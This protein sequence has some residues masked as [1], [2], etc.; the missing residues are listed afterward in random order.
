MNASLVRWLLWGAASAIGGALWTVKSVS[1]LLVNRQ[2][3]FTFEF[4]PFFFGIAVLGVVRTTA[5]FRPV[6]VW[7]RSLAWL[8]VVAGAVA[9]VTYLV[10]RDGVLFGSAIATAMLAV[11]DG[12]SGSGALSRSPWRGS[13]SPRSPSAELWLKSMNGC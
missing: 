6:A 9:A 10:Q 12:S 2:P 13:R 8:A 4:A 1:I 11:A 7:L 5:H 3:D